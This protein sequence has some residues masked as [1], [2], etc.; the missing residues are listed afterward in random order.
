MEKVLD[1]VKTEAKQNE[2]LSALKYVEGIC[3]E[4]QAQGDDGRLDRTAE[5]VNLMTLKALVLSSFEL[6]NVS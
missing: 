6:S 1:R 3:D 5:Q 2:I 4:G